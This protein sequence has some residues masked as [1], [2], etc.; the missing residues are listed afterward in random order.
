MPA[1]PSAFF[2]YGTLQQG[3]ERAKFWPRKP[4]EIL[5]ARVQGALYDL[6]PYPALV[7]G[8]DWVRGELWVLAEE[9]MAETIRVLDA[10]EG[11]AQP[12]ERDWYRREVIECTL[13]DG[14][15]QPAFV[16]Y[17]ARPDEIRHHPQVRPGSDGM[18]HWPTG[19]CSEGK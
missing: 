8:E 19:R 16:Y 17:F 10:V 1:G 4:R 6:G 9:D 3:E 14:A 13:E 2:V 18:R 12:S 15:R 5:P 7:P 11:Y